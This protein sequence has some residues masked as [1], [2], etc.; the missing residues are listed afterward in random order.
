MYKPSLEIKKNQKKDFDASLCIVCQKKVDRAKRGSPKKEVDVS[1]LDVFEILGDNRYTPILFRMP[2]GDN[3]Q[4][5][6]LFN[7]LDLNIA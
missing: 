7:T 1:S 2:A 6:S 3:L 5:A 4:Y